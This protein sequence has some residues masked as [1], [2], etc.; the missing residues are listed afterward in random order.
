MGG[1]G[2]G[3]EGGLEFVIFFTK[4]PA[5]KKNFSV[6]G[7]RGIDGWTDKQAKINLPLQ[8]LRSRGLNNE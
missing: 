2:G 6:G 4:S 1:R 3:E 8:L 7:S 5:L